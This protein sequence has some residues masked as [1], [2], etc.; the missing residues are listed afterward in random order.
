[1]QTFSLYVLWVTVI[2]Q[3][4][5]DSVYIRVSNMQLSLATTDVCKP[6]YWSF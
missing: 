2:A 1:M 4:E 5:H 6:D 3:C